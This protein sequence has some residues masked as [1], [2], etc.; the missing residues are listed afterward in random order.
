MVDEQALRRPDFVEGRRILLANGQAWSFPDHPPLRDD[1]EQIAALRAIGESED[2]ADRLRAELALTI[3]L[4]SRNYDL[5]PSDYQAIL[6][7]RPSDPALAALQHAIHEL[8]VEQLRALPRLS[9]AYSN[10][11]PPA[12]RM[13]HW[14]LARLFRPRSRIGKSR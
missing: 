13:T 6:G 10:S 9:G 7:F 3:L 14:S 2:Q 4:L 1:A 5:S 8:A 11:N 12:P